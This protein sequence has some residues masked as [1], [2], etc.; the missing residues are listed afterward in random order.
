[1]SA[2]QTKMWRK[3]IPAVDRDRL[4]ELLEMQST[5]P[6]DFRPHPKIE[7]GIRQRRQMARGERPLDWAAGEALAFATLATEEARVRL[8]GQDSESGTFSHRHAVLHDVENG[9]DIQ[10]FSESRAGIRPR[11]RSTTARFLKLACLDFEYGYSLDTPDG[12]VAWEAQFGDFWNAAQVIVDQFIAAAEDK[13]RR[14]SGITLLLPHGMEGQ[15]PG[16]FQRPA[17]TISRACRRRQYPGRPTH[18]ARTTV[19]LP[20]TPGIT[21]MEEAACCNDA[22]ESSAESPGNFPPG[23]I[24]HGPL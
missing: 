17:G 19:S 22:K 4:V 6:D 5:V 16:T 7:A 10:A 1:M 23:R 2:G 13:W 12:L 11:S 9:R 15:G 8:S 24:C 3:S 20:A 18:D 21:A 14:L